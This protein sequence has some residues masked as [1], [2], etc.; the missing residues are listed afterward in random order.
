MP[1]IRHKSE[2]IKSVARRVGWDREEVAKVI[3]AILEELAEAFI[4]QERVEI[5]GFGV[6]VPVHRKRKMND[7]K[8]PRIKFKLSWVIRARMIEEEKK[9]REE[10]AL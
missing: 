4:R 3:D 6:F 10:Y 1:Y 8:L 7:E 5:R 9:R 2:I